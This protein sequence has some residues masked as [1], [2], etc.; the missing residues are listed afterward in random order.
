MVKSEIELG[1]PFMVLDVVHLL[2]GTYDIERK[3]KAR[4]TDIRTWVKL[5]D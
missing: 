4:W 5:N 1:L 3:S 2:P